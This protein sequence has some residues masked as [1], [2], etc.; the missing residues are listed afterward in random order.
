MLARGPAVPADAL[1]FDWCG[2]RV[3]FAD[4]AGVVDADGRRLLEA[5]P[6]LAVADPDKLLAASLC[7]R[8]GRAA[9]TG[10]GGTS[11]VRLAVAEGIAVRD[12][13]GPVHTLTMRHR[14]RGY[15]G[16]LSRALRP[17]RNYAMALSLYAPRL[18]DV[19]V[20]ADGDLDVVAVQDDR[21]LAWLRGRDGLAA[22]PAVEMDLAALVRAGEDAD[23]RTQ[24]VDI[25]GDGR[26]ELVV[27]VVRGAVPERSEIWIASSGAA[28]FS[29]VRRAV[30]TDG[31]AAALDVRRGGRGVVVAAIDTS[32]VSLSTVLLTGRLEVRVRVDDAEPMILPAAVDVRGA[33]LVGALPIVSV[34]FDGDGHEDLLDLG[35]PGVAALHLGRRGRGG[36][37]ASPA[38]R[39]DVPGFQQ[40]VAL[41]AQRAIALI[42]APEAG[43]T[44]G[45][46]GSGTGG[47]TR[48]AVVRLDGPAAARGDGR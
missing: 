27:G 16:R 40:A 43:R 34:D 48:V 5:T 23:L 32:L 22:T 14:A 39:W 3:V 30:A 45:K 36:F 11:E 26:A 28:P 21:A 24:V 8:G 9:G 44:T 20:D 25:E 1:A 46:A 38:A 6:L 2:G 37:E 18:V 29:S 7:P 12:G 47:K 42:G 17:E 4:D 19:D 13:D 33:R 15:P 41:P 10:A 31:F 35:L